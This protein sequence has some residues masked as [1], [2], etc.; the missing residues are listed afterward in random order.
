LVA[1]CEAFLAGHYLEHLDPP[2][3]L[4]PPWAWLNLVAH[5]TP[6]ELAAAS[7]MNC[8]GSPPD[9]RARTW[10]DARAFLAAEVLE[11]AGGHPGRLKDLQARVLVPIELDLADA[12]D[13]AYS[14]RDMVSAVLR[15]LDD[16]RRQCRR[17][18]DIA[19]REPPVAT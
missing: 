12:G 1:D 19:D 17:R 2:L 6:G 3:G 11:A 16:E 4:A 7:G 9:R 18:R 14:P 8:P 13:I 5:A 15:A 10:H